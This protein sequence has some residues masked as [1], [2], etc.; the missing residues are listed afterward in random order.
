MNRFMTSLSAVVLVLGAV[1]LT[2]IASAGAD[3]TPTVTITPNTGVTNGQVLVVTGTG[4][5]SGGYLAMVECA[6]SATTS[7]GCNLSAMVTFTVN[8]DGTIPATNFPAQSGTVGNSSC[9]TSATDATCA[10]VVGTLLGV[11]LANATFTFAAAT[12]STTTTT[13]PSTTTTTTPSTTTTMFTPRTLT[14]RPSTGL[15]N[16]A[17]VTVSGAGFTAA[18]HVYIVECLVGSSSS[19]GCNLKGVKAVTISETG[20]LPATTFKVVAGKVGNGTCGTTRAN[21][22]RCAISVA[23]ATKGDSKVARITFALPKK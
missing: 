3:G 14:V 16:G 9:G 20:V 13:T 2:G 17:S 11:Q 5:S 12:T 1:A 4:F 19:S 7:A 23:N 21:L 6:S 10:I 18:D 8:A 15:K 22:S